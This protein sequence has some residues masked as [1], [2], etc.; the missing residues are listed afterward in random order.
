MTLCTVWYTILCKKKRD[1]SAYWLSLVFA[2]CC[3]MWLRAMN[4]RHESV[5]ISSHHQATHYTPFDLKWELPNETHGCEN[6]FYSV[7]CC[8]LLFLIT[9]PK[10]VQLLIKKVH[11]NCR[12]C[13]T[14]RYCMSLQLH[15]GGR[16]NLQCHRVQIVFKLFILYFHKNK[17]CNTAP[18]WICKDV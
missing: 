11:L 17:K 3:I 5:S 13:S 7:P 14:N 15:V 18:A 4:C 12:R 8:T 2:F 16:G 1:S 10:I 6:L 9:L